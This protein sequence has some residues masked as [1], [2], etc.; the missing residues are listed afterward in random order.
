MSDTDMLYMA[1]LQHENESMK[2]LLRETLP[3]LHRAFFANYKDTNAA[4]EL[5]DKIKKVVG[6]AE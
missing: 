4:N 6:G 3:V 5:Y 2:K 1:S